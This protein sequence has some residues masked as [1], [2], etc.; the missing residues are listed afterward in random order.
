[1]SRGGMFGGPGSGPGGGTFPGGNG[2]GKRPEK[3]KLDRKTVKSILWRL[4]GYVMNYWYLFLPA[5]VMTLFSNQLALLGPKYSG[6]ATDA[7]AAEGGV[8]IKHHRC[9][10]NSQIYGTP[11]NK[12][13]QISPKHHRC[14]KEMHILVA[15]VIYIQNFS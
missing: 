4:C 2:E 14:D 3:K 15:P 6:I 11:L 1:M 10:I 8:Q 12:L 9:D 13:R 7:I 5:V